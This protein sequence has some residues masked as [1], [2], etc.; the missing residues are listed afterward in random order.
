MHPW[1]LV[2]F[3]ASA[4]LLGVVLGILIGAYLSPRMED[5]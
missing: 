2:A 4:F 5:Q 1:A 3:V